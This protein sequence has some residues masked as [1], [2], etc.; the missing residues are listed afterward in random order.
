M[1]ISNAHLQGFHDFNKSK[2]KPNI[3]MNIFGIL[4]MTKFPLLH[5]FELCG[6]ALRKN[7]KCK[8]IYKDFLHP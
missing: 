3:K 7:N 2:K 5:R 6:I 8:N 4:N 1:A